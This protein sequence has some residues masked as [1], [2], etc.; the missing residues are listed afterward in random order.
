LKSVVA[1]TQTDWAPPP[2]I[3]VIN[4]GTMHFYDKK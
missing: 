4:D 2:E 3:P 1:P